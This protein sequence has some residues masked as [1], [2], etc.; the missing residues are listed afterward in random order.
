ML[1]G[2]INGAVLKVQVSKLPNSMRTTLPPL[3]KTLQQ[4][5]PNKLKVILSLLSN[6]DL[7]NHQ[8]KLQIKVKVVQ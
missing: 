4:D 6:E 3:F 7:D 8:R 2:K 1:L 5:K